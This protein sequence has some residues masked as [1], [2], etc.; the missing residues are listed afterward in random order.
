MWI[1]RK[2]FHFDY[3][4]RSWGFLRVL[5]LPSELNGC[6]LPSNATM[7]GRRTDDAYWTYRLISSIVMQ[8]QLGSPLL[9]R[10]PLCQENDR[11][12]MSAERKRKFFSFLPSLRTFW[13]A[14]RKF[15]DNRNNDTVDGEKF[16]ERSTACQ[17]CFSAAV[18][19]YSQRED[20]QDS[21]D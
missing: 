14:M 7:D 5:M 20:I 18:R 16:V 1:R 3:S 17:R 2:E 4:S 11:S 21:P 13:L 10:S 8:K 15:R 19:T 12:D 6:L 9:F